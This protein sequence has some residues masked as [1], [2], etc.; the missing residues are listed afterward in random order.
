PGLPAGVAR[1]WVVLGTG[2][3]IGKTFVSRSLVRALAAAGLPV[4]GLKPIETGIRD[5]GGP[6]DARELAALGF[7][8]R[9]PAPHPL[10]AFAEPVAP[11]LAS[12]AA[13][14]R[15][16]LERIARW[17]DDAGSATTEPVHVVVETAGGVF[18]PLSDRHT[19]FDLARAL[20]PATWILV[21]PNRL[22]VLHDVTSAL[23]AMTALGRRP[24]WL[25][26]S[27]SETADLSSSSN[28]DE[29]SRTMSTPPIVELP[30]DDAR[31]LA[32]L[33]AGVARRT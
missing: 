10:Y 26:L 13:G 12:R 23:V 7:D 4:A 22:G 21:A 3:G 33:L 32:A 27:A 17:V 20:E 2:T 18:S 11:S 1:R 15:I 30:R 31:P 14:T 16:E 25:V 6:S 28:R 29:L 9:L 5:D 8:A 19:N 24:D